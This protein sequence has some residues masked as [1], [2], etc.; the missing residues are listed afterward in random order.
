[1]TIT[2]ADIEA[3]ARQI[4]SAVNDTKESAQNTAVLA[5]VAVLLVVGISYLMG[6]RKARSGR[7][8]VEVYR[9]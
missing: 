6:R 1:M 3:K 4:T 8:V 7:A 2:R 9:I 5:G